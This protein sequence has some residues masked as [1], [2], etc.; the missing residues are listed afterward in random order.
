MAAP[1]RT[2]LITV[3][4]DD[5]R[6]VERVFAQLESEPGAGDRK[7]V[8]DHVIAELVRHS[9]AEEQLVYRA[10]R[11]HLDDGDEIADHE[12]EKH[13]ETE[14]LMKGLERESPG[15][16]EY[17]ELLGKLI[18]DVRRHIRDEETG[19]LPRLREACSAGELDQL[20]ERVLAAKK[21]APSPRRRI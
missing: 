13:A 20:G 9:V 4:T 11:E 17:E 15:E 10:A 7:E 3:I 6:D 19:L 12:I 2:D 8:V 16:P 21:V 18:A 14:K 1:T 5:H